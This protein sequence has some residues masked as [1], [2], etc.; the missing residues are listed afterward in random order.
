[1][2]I[3][4]PDCGVELRDEG[5]NLICANHGIIILGSESSSDE[6]KSKGE[7]YIG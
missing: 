2:S 4:C 6:S 7:G 3:N 5:G 1:M